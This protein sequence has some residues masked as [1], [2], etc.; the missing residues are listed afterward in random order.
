MVD[1]TKQIGKV[2]KEHKNYIVITSFL[3]GRFWVC[4]LSL[5]FLP[6]RR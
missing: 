6:M 2:Q 1:V 5:I 3:K 4:I